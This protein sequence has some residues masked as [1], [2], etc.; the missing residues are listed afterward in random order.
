MR[1]REREIAVAD[2]EMFSKETQQHTYQQQDNIEQSVILV[3]RKYLT[4][5]AWKAST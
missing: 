3:I 2:D 1:K 4:K 5:Q